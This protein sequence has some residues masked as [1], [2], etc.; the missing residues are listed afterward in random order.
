MTSDST[1]QASGSNFYRVRRPGS[2]GGR[3]GAHHVFDAAVLP[4]VPGPRREMTLTVSGPIAAPGGEG[5]G[6]QTF[7]VHVSSHLSVQALLGLL[8]P[9]F[10]QEFG[11]V[12]VGVGDSAVL[13]NAGEVGASIR[14]DRLGVQGDPVVLVAGPY[15][16]AATI[17]SIGPY[18]VAGYVDDAPVEVDRAFR[19]TANFATVPAAQREAYT[20][21]LLV[22]I[23]GAWVLAYAAAHQGVELTKTGKLKK[24]FLQ[25]AMESC[26]FLPLFAT[27]GV[28]GVRAQA[29][30]VDTVEI[31]RDLGA[32]VQAPD[33]GKKG[34]PVLVLGAQ[35]QQL[36][37][38]DAP[39]DTEVQHR[40]AMDMAR[41]YATDV[42]EWYQQ[43]VE[44]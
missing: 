36:V 31:L 13:I 24:A 29:P 35:W 44:A 17:N 32:L 15:Q 6:E 3:G 27:P 40:L 25:D 18:T 28:I 41:A 20:R 12:K 38:P 8:S 4:G 7:R 19:R 5:E 16:F 43:L 14:V 30:I 37:N 42:P 10:G 39:E 21:Q 1:P 26:P 33:A 11:G 2:L 22:A 23:M 34:G 9:L